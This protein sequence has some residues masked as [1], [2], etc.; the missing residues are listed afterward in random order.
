VNEQQDSIP[1][2]NIKMVVFTTGKTR[3]LIEQ[4]YISTMEP[5]NSQPAVISIEELLETPFTDSTSQQLKRL[6][7]INTD[8]GQFTL[9]VD[10]PVELQELPSQS[11]RPLPLLIAARNELPYLRAMAV[12]EQDIGLI[13]DPMLIDSKAG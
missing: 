8:N 2:K 6:L 1:A 4:S 3:V 10:E 11:I 9:A 13:I 7:I 12:L 5:G